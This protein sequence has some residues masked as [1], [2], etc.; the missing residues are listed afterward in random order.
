M[1]SLVRD[2]VP[3]MFDPGLVEMNLEICAGRHERGR[4]APA[5]IRCGRRFRVSGCS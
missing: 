4:V 2:D 1:K 3:D 5:T